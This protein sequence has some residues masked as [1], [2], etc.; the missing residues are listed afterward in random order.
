MDTDKST[1]TDRCVP[2]GISYVAGAVRISEQESEPNI[3]HL[4]VSAGKS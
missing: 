3:Q 2:V 4:N 1:G